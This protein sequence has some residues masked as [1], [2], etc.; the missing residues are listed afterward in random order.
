MYE[1][2]LLAGKGL[3]LL[4]FAELLL[5]VSVVLAGLLKSGLELAALILSLVG[6]HRTVTSH[7]LFR[8][9]FHLT[10]AQPVIYILA[11]L[12]TALGRQQLR[13]ASIF[14]MLFSVAILVLQFY[15]VY[16]VCMAAG[17]L[18]TAGGFDAEAAR[19]RTAWKFCLADTE[20]SLLSVALLILPA[21]MPSIAPWLM[22]SEGAT[23]LMLTLTLVMGI[24]RLAYF[25]IYLMFLYHA[26]LALLSGD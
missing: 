25:I 5:A 22:W 13:V 20:I 8:R 19:G 16:L 15:I 9:A 6:L 17:E 21:L 18:L 2:N 12:L 3:K 14:A 10:I 1:D 11:A 4:F 23:G 24:V 26:Y 7:P